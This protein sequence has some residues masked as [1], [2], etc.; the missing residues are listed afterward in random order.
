MKRIVWIAL[1]IL[2]IL[3]VSIPNTIGKVA[4]IDKQLA[5]Y[6]A[7]IN[8]V[9]AELG[10]TIYIP[11]KNKVTVYNNIKNMTPD[12]FET[13][14][15]NEYLTTGSGQSLNIQCNEG[16][17]IQDSIFKKNHNKK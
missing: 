3:G 13:K 5:P 4:T 11:D 6:Q 7:V 16:D 17:Y 14:I 12:E 2:L 15:R 8:K 1:F 9:N 10:S